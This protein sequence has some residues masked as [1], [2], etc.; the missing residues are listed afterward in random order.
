M[1]FVA[2]GL[3]S[4]IEDASA[5]A[6]HLRV[7]RVSLDLHFLRGFDGRNDHRT[8]HAVGDRNIV[9]EVVIPSDWSAGDADLR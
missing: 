8:V 4:C 6:A 5:G 3:Q 7:V 9:N 1:Q 2:S